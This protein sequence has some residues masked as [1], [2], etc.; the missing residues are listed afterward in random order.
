MDN[1]TKQ[2]KIFMDRAIELALEAEKE[3][4]LPIG[5]L[6]VL[7]GKIIAEGKN[8]IFCPS[9]GFLNHAEID[10]ISK[11]DGNLFA[12]R[13][14]EMTLF[15]N[16]EPCLMCFGTIVLHKIGKVVFGGS[17]ANKGA[18][19]LVDHLEKIYSKEQ[20]PKFVGPVCQDI[21]GPMWER[22]NK[23]YRKALENKK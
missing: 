9:F 8:A 7:D 13:G 1:L 20:L 11:V 21:C 16:T 10:A 22:A 4:N 17:D 3:G 18:T 5:A 15:T 2:D 19:Y 14:K 23:I 12:T 6:I